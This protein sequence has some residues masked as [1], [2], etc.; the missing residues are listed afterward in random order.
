Y[1]IIQLLLR[2]ISSFTETGF[3]IVKI[4]MRTLITSQLFIFFM[5][6]KVTI[7][8]IAAVLLLKEELIVIMEI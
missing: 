6:K 4:I 1:T 2:T 5:V 7:G 3:T 8:V